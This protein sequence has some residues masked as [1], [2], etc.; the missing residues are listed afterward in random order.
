MEPMQLPGPKAKAL[1]AR[2]QAVISPSYPSGYP[3]VMDHGKG[4]EVWD[5]DGNHSWILRLVLR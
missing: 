5:V 2:D 4:T 3:F 1:I